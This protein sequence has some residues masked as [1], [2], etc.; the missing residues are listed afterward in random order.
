M[1][2]R[3]SLYLFIIFSLVLLKGREDSKKVDRRTKV[4]IVIV[5]KSSVSG[6]VSSNV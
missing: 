3:V 6:V 1:P 4:L 2:S 5:I